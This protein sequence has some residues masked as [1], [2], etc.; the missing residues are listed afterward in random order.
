MAT[1]NDLAHRVGG[2]VHAERERLARRRPDLDAE[3]L[4]AVEETLW[5][6]ADYLVLR[7][8]HHVSADPIAVARLWDLGRGL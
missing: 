5:R 8:L 3:D 1:H 4:A 2:I 6:I 7:H